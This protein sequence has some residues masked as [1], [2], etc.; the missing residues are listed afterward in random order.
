MRHV[1]LQN[2]H[3][4]RSIE[5]FYMRCKTW[6]SE[7]GG[8]RWNFSLIPKKT[9]ITVSTFRNDKVMPLLMVFIRFFRGSGSCKEGFAARWSMTSLIG[10][11]AGSGCCKRLLL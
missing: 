5:V 7:V 9:K 2:I 6:H 3:F 10:L 4:D 1:N 8:R 11:L